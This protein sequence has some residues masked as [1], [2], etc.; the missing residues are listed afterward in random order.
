MGKLESLGGGGGGGGEEASPSPPPDKTLQ[1]IERCINGK[2][3][4]AVDGCSSVVRALAAQAREVSSIHGGYPC[5]SFPH[6]IFSQHIQHLTIMIISILIMC[7]L[8]WGILI[9]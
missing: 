8:L 4:V 9:S 6:S 5:I 2:D 7:H 1:D 3:V